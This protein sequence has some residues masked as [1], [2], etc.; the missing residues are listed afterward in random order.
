MDP[1]RFKFLNENEIENVMDGVTPTN[2]HRNTGWATNVWDVWANA[3]NRARQL[4]Q[5]KTPLAHEIEYC[6]AGD[7]NTFLTHFILEVRN[8]KGEFCPS[9]TLY[10]LCAGIC[11]FLRVN[12]NRPDLNFFERKQHLFQQGPEG[13]GCANAHNDK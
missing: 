1:S 9:K 6:T 13:P 3:R 12:L 8:S 5:P 7:F 10:N 11:R 2:T 4:G